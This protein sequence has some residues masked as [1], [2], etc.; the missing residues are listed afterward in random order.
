M[1]LFIR[2]SV[3]PTMSRVSFSTPDAAFGAEPN[4]TTAPMSPK[5]V[6]KRMTPFRS[7]TSERLCPRGLG[8]GQQFTFFRQMEQQ[9]LARKY[10]RGI[11]MQRSATAMPGT[12]VHARETQ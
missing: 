1:K 12:A 9:H 10:G 11:K 6:K 8:P 5:R 4:S 3:C 2:M 7:L